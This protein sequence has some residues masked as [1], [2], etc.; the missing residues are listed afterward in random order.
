MSILSWIRERRA[1]LKAK[2]R[3]LTPIEESLRVRKI[4]LDMERAQQRAY[5][6]LKQ[7]DV[8]E[9]NAKTERHENLLLCIAAGGRE[10]PLVPSAEEVERCFRAEMER[11]RVARSAAET[12]ESARRRVIALS[13]GKQWPE[14]PS[15]R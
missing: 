12:P 7:L 9:S 13:R 5:L 8:A 14:Y 10:S 1:A 2:T 6:V 3:T 4:G 15:R 11:I